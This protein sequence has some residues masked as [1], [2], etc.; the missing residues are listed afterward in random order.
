MLT[1]DLD[2]SQLN[3]EEEDFN[4]SQEQSS[5]QQQINTPTPS[6]S[7]HERSTRSETRSYLQN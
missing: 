7:V 1:P 3:E 6:Q 2:F 4:S 5:S